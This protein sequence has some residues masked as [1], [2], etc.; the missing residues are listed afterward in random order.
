MSYAF[1]TVTRDDGATI[2]A[3]YGVPAVCQRDGCTEQ[4]ARGLDSLCGSAPGTPDDGCGGYFCSRH[5]YLAWDTDEPRPQNCRP[6]TDQR[7]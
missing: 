2:E 6:C 4:I 1:Y 7:I 3:G 5:L